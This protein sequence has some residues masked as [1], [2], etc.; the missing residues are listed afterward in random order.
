MNFDEAADGLLNNE[1]AFSLSNAWIRFPKV[2][3]SK[4]ENANLIRYDFGLGTMDERDD[5]VLYL[6]TLTTR[7]KFEPVEVSTQVCRFNVFR[8]ASFT[9]HL[10]LTF[11]SASYGFYDIG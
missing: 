1:Y 2:K 8:L 9:T 7:F 3:K 4:Q 5:F 11:T 6:I 10:R